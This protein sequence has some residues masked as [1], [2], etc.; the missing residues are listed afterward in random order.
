MSQRLIIGLIHQQ[1]SL[2]RFFAHLL[3]CSLNCSRIAATSLQQCPRLASSPIK[4]VIVAA[5]FM[6][7]NALVASL[8]NASKV[9]AY[10]NGALFGT[11][12]IATCTSITLARK[13]FNTLREQ[14]ALDDDEANQLPLSGS[15]TSATEVISP[16][17]EESPEDANCALCRDIPQNY[18]TP[19]HAK[20]NRSCNESTDFDQ[21]VLIELSPQTEVPGTSEC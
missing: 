15:V 21:S 8:L 7:C 14:T 19:I 17:H 2:I 3:S 16:G 6:M 18:N 11:A 13:H 1:V 4:C 5:F 12:M 20:S 10:T 9:V